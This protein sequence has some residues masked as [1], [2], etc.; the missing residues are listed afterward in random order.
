MLKTAKLNPGQRRCRRWSSQY[1]FAQNT[2]DRLDKYGVFRHRSGFRVA[3]LES[4]LELVDIHYDN[5]ANG[6]I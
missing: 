1:S 3:L 6:W 2:I 5:S 4:N